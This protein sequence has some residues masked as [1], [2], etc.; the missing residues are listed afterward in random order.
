[1][2]VPGQL[3]I[4]ADY[5]DFLEKNHHPDEWRELVV[6]RNG[7]SLAVTSCADPRPEAEV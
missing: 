7:S 4:E 1:M 2:T 5:I 3:R 6:V